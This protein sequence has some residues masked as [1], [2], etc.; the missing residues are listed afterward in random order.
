MGLYET[1]RRHL[2]A[3]TAIAV[4]TVIAGPAYVG[5]KV[6]VYEDGSTE[7]DLDLPELR[8]KI[9]SD[10]LQLLY[11]ERS[12][13]LEYVVNDD[14]Y[15]VFVDSFPA[16]PQLII[17]GASHAAAP[18]SSFGKRAGYRVVICDARAAFAV[19]DRFPDADQVLKG[20]PQDVLPSLALGSNT[21]LV[22]L[23]H[24]SRFDIPTLEIALPSNVRYIGAIGSR[25]TQSQRF[26]RLRAEGYTPEQLARIYGPVGL[27][28]GSRTPEET[29]LAILAE[30]TA[31]RYGAGAGFLRDRK[32]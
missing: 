1:F 24:D 16:P 31:V 2:E 30:I 22:L 17:V 11:D 8:E 12:S 4:V 23:S 26:E 6:L 20:W 21:Y 15:S 7:G 32:R 10:A 28:I 13:T 14:T 25:R 18:L 27:D 29:A 9:A 19:A 5:F 3:E